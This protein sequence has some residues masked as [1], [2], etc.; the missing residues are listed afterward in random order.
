MKYGM[1]ILSLEESD[2][3]DINSLTKIC[4]KINLDG[5]EI[6][7]PSLTS[8]SWQ[9]IKSIKDVLDESDLEVSMLTLTTDFVHPD[10]DV[11][12][13]NRSYLKMAAELARR[14]ET[15]II[16]VT[17]HHHPALS[18]QQAVRNAKARMRE[19]LRIA[20]DE[21]VVL[22]L[23]NHPGDIENHKAVLKEMFATFDT[24]R[25]K[26]NYDPANAFIVNEDPVSTLREL[27]GKVV[28]IHA[29]NCYVTEEGKFVAEPADIW[30]GNTDYRVLMSILNE[31]GYDGFF[32]LQL[33]G[34]TPEQSLKR[35][36]TYLR[37]LERSL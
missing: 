15:R 14:F 13:W 22:A 9:Y 7:L 26:L 3:R 23:E 17:L 16:R 33:A 18:L 4:K 35:S 11:W 5:V 21:D 10:E 27:I 20:E 1:M 24:E 29:K 36:V 25:L 32:S 34:Q 19:A 6:W 30:K 31:V 2:Q 8:L 12:R 37:E 28:H